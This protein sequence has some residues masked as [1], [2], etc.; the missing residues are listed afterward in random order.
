MLS[1]R[2][3]KEFNGINYSIKNLKE[4]KKLIT[5]CYKNH[6]IKVTI[7]DSYPFKAPLQVMLNNRIINHDYFFNLPT[8]VKK[9]VYKNLNGVCCMMCSSYLCSNNW[10]PSLRII[11]SINQILLYREKIKQAHYNEYVYKYGVLPLCNDLI[12]HILDFL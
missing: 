7:C 5:F 12:D 9:R 10:A 3:E 1:R 6:D 8:N 2:L 11:D 4:K